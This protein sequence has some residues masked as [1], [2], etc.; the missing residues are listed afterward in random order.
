MSRDL[1]I[2]ERAAAENGFVCICGVD[3]AGRGPLAGPVYAAACVLPA[4]IE[5]EGLDDSKKLSEKKRDEV[6]DRILAVAEDWCVA[7]A[8]VEEIEQL[9][10]LNATM[11]AMRR[12]IRG[13][14]KLPDMA[15]ID[16]NVAREMPCQARTIAGGDGKSASIAAASILAKVSRDRYMQELDREYPAYGFAKHKGY[17]TKQ[18]NDAI[19]ANGPCPHHRLS[20]LSGLVGLMKAPG[21]DE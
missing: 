6:Y 19:I 14:K 11:L 21:K 5:I 2:F 9:N 8:S 7:S 4:G 15:L 13:L 16:G 18:H 20:F 1:W 12:A 17:G 10:I 3:E